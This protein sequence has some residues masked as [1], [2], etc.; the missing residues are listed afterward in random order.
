MTE[1]MGVARPIDLEIIACS[2]DDALAAHDG[3]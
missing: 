1:A 2:L 3:R